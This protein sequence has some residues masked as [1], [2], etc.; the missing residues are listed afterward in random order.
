V[1]RIDDNEYIL[2]NLEVPLTSKQPTSD[3]SIGSFATINMGYKQFMQ[4]K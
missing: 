2:L 1:S 4:S 3:D